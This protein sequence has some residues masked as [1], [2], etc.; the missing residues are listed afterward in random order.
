MSSRRKTSS[1]VLG[2]LESTRAEAFLLDLANTDTIN[3]SMMNADQLSMDLATSF[4]RRY[5]E[6][7]EPLGNHHPQLWAETLTWI[8]LCLQKAWRATDDD[9]KRQWCGYE[10]RRHYR[11]AVTVAAFAATKTEPKDLP[12]FFSALAHIGENPDRVDPRLID[13]PPKTPFEAAVVYFQEHIRDRAKYCRNE[14]C[15][16]QRYFIAKKRWQRYCSEACVGPANRE[17]KRKW[18][19]ENHPRGGSQ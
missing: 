17:S 10:M 18:W 16:E 19:R 5:P 11:D 6:M 3:V 7:F 4:Q 1:K 15:S 13:P 9:R 2:V 14:N 8:Q 12:V